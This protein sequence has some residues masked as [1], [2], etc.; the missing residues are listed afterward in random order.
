MTTN[1]LLVRSESWTLPARAMALQPSAS[2]LASINSVVDAFVWSGLSSEAGVTQQL[3]QL[4]GQPVHLRELASLDKGTFKTIVDGWKIITPAAVPSVAIG[5]LTKASGPPGSGTSIT[6]TPVQKV[7]A[8]LGFQAARLKMGLPFDLSDTAAPAA[9]GASLVPKIKINQVFDQTMEQEVTGMTQREYTA[10]VDVHVAKL[11]REPPDGVVPTPDQTKVIEEINNAGLCPAAADFAVFGPHG[12]S[13]QRKLKFSPQVLVN[14]V[15]IIQELFG[16]PTVK[17]WKAC[18]KVLK[19]IF[20]FLRLVEP[21]NVDNYIEFIED[22]E[23][24]YGKRAWGVIYQ[25]DVKMRTQEMPRILARLEKKWLAAGSPQHGGDPDMFNPAMPWDLVFHKAICGGKANSWWMRQAREPCMLLST[26][27]AEESDLIGE[28][29][30][31]AKAGTHGEPTLEHEDLSWRLPD[32]SNRSPG[33]AKAKAKAG[34]REKSRTP[35]GEDVSE[36]N[37]A[38]EYVRNKK[39][40]ELCQKYKSG[41]CAKSNKC[42]IN[43]ERT[44]QCCWCLAQH[45][46]ESCGNSSWK[47]PVQPGGGNKGGKAGKGGKSGKS[48][49]SFRGGGAW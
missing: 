2:E 5:S 12:A 37:A 31:H 18:M 48:G 49:K 6:A 25:A 10:L 30:H 45:P 13:I 3:L 27:I 11:G 42:P 22:L 36:Q 44:H 14:G 23:A 21:Q 41:N 43:P 24:I 29:V 1:P 35:R 4:L 16:P 19:V 32:R 9:P 40:L 38:G 33:G 34:A 20:I 39:G 7:R 28:E 8:L 17:M 47:W 46:G 15:W 26:R